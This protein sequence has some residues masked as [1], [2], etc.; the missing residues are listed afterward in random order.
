MS[1]VLKLIIR[2]WLTK[3]Q[4]MRMLL[5]RTLCIVYTVITYSGLSLS[6]MRLYLLCFAHP[7]CVFDYLPENNTWW[8][9]SWLYWTCLGK[10]AS[11]V[12]RTSTKICIFSINNYLK[13]LF[14][15]KNNVIYWGNC[16]YLHVC[17]YEL[18]YLTLCRYLNVY[19]SFIRYVNNTI[20]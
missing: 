3:H 8:S 2:S 14:L 12:Y 6:N 9:N 17:L 16:V 13:A 20:T 5:F 10:L 15:K 18:T 1:V 4:W 11:A 7:L 19:M